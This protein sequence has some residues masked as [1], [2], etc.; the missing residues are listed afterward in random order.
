MLVDERT[1]KKRPRAHLSARLRHDAGS[2]LVTVL[3]VMLVLTIAGVALASIAMRT[4]VTVTNTRDR[5]SAQAEVDG[6]IASQT[7][8]L[9]K[10]GLICDPKTFDP[11]GAAL[12]P[13]EPLS[14][15]MTNGVGSVGVNW[16]LKCEESGPAGARVGTA[17]ITADATVGKEI[18]KRTATF[19]YKPIRDYINTDGLVF[20]DTSTIAL[21]PGTTV[22]TPDA[23]MN[24]FIPEAGFECKAIVWGNVVAGDSIDV[25]E[26][27]E[28]HGS[29][30]SLS[31]QVNVTGRVD[32]NIKIG[33]TG[34]SGLGG[35]IQGTVWS[36]GKV[37]ASGVITGNLLSLGNVTLDG[38]VSGSVTVPSSRSFTGDGT[39]GTLSRPG[40][41]KLPPLPSPPP[42]FE[43]TYNAAEWTGHTT[44]TLTAKG[45]G[46]TSCAAW[47]KNATAGWATLA[48][49]PGKTVIDGRACDTLDASS[50]AQNELAHDTLLLGNGFELQKSTWKAAD[51]VPAGT[52]PKIWFVTE[53]LTDNQKPTCIDK[54]MG[55]NL[56]QVSISPSVVGMIYT[57]C[58]VQM[59]S[60]S[61]P[62]Q[63]AIYSGN[64]NKGANQKFGYGD[65]RLPGMPN[66][67]ESGAITGPSEMGNVVLNSSQPDS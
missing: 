52:Q 51:T 50:T 13:G 66:D 43:F 36:Y 65:I 10:G 41:L 28:I 22:G 49:R 9:L 6:G 63:G 8:A 39:Y 4:T 42:W 47:E 45:S 16:V 67:E 14:G 11:S 32:G 1:Q 37:N 54:K 57:P 35:Q 30:T 26:Q 61:L 62:W 21:N 27:C 23:P 5:A 17:T 25:S 56:F 55:T 2:T 38:T 44:V 3:I 53:D 12:E 18:V 19:T 31:G 34:T 59:G 48:T 33:G 29:V 24:I 20:Y 46:V 40:S 58:E 15:T 64:Y 60:G 7:V